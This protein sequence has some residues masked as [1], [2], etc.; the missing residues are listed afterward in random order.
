[1]NTSTRWKQLERD[2]AQ[3]LGGERVTEH[4]TLFRKRP[5]VVAPLPDGARL[6]I[7]CKAHRR[8]AHHRHLEKVQGEY[9]HPGDVPAIVTREYGERAYIAVP[10]EWLAALLNQWRARP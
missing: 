10:L 5:D 7:D 1:M 4:W 2:A 6:V 3:A 8:H 9:C